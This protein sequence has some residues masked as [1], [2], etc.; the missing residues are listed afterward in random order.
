MSDEDRDYVP[1]T[2]A[3]RHALSWALILNVALSAALATAGLLADSSA[4]IVMLLIVAAGVVADVVRRFIAGPEPMGPVIMGM[5][6]IAAT[7]NVLCLRLLRSSNRDGAQKA[8]ANAG[9][10]EGGSVSRRRARRP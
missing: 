9:F 2:Q 3:E 4:L 5:A 6:I 1:K 8:G 7:V 10:D